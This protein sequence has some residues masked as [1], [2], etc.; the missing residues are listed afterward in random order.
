M[1]AGIRWVWPNVWDSLDA[2]TDGFERIR[3]QAALLEGAY[4]GNIV[5]R[6][7]CFG[8]SFM[9]IIC[10]YVCMYA[11][12]YVCMYVCMHVCMYVYACYHLHIYV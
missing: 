9:L 1:R 2:P 10:M 3:W 7:V 6:D 4:P 5:N 12:M 11:C 8:C